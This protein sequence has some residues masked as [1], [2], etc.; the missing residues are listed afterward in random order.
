M[1]N[2]GNS[3]YLYYK[4]QDQNQMDLG[5]ENPP[6]KCQVEPKII[7]LEYF[8]KKRKEKKRKEEKE[9]KEE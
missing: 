9:E 2:R 4:K 5:N 6:R 8:K 7:S 3:N 1:P